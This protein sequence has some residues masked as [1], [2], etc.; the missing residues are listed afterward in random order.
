MSTENIKNML[1]H[2]IDG[3]E[4]AAKAELTTVIK[5]KTQD[6]VSNYQAQDVTTDDEVEEIE[7]DKTSDEV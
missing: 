2:F 4:D 6:I 1:Q 3:D 7:L 5:Q